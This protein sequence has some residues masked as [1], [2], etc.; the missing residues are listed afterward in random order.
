MEPYLVVVRED[1]AA[2]A[3]RN[4]KSRYVIMVNEVD[5]QWETP[6]MMTVG[7]LPREAPDRDFRPSFIQ[8]LEIARNGPPSADGG[9]PESSS[10]TL[11]GF[12][13]SGAQS[14]EVSSSLDEY[15]TDVADDGFVLA[16]LRS[17]WREKPAVVVAL[18]DGRRIPCAH[19]SLAFTER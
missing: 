12:V 14:I 9:P 3:L 7:E 19:P 11:S 6:Q 1:V 8:R 18:S 17:P 16:V 4:A 5:G 10:I 2:V 13:A 15:V